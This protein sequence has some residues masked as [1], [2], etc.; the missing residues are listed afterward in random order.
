MLAAKYDQVKYNHSKKQLFDVTEG[1]KAAL[2]VNTPPPPPHTKCKEAHFN[3]KIPV[4]SPIDSA[5]ETMIIEYLYFKNHFKKLMLYDTVTEL[6]NKTNQ[7]H[8]HF[9]KTT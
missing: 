8:T 4:F 9:L 2:K 5:A 7:A 3:I 6:A 1:L